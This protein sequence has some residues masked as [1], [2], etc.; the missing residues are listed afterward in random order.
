MVEFTGPCGNRSG[1][2]NSL[3]IATFGTPCYGSRKEANSPKIL[4]QGFRKKAQRRKGGSRWLRIAG[5]GSSGKA[6]SLLERLGRSAGCDELKRH[7]GPH[8]ICP[9]RRHREPVDQPEEKFGK[10]SGLRAV[11]GG[12]VVECR[13]GVMRAEGREI[14]HAGGVG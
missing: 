8:R 9:S 10:L 3:T 14:R 4:G 2:E 1:R 12:D 11:R 7:G 6:G 13:V 5:G